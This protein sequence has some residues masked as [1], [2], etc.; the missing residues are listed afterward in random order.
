MS[1]VETTLGVTCACVPPIAGF[2]RKTWNQFRF[3]NRSYFWALKVWKDAVAIL[4]SGGTITSGGGTR[5]AFPDI[6]G[7][8]HVSVHQV[9]DVEVAPASSHSRSTEKQS[10]IEVS[11]NPAK[12]DEAPSG[13]CPEST[14]QRPYGDM[15]STQQARAKEEPGVS[16]VE[17]RKE[18]LPEGH[19]EVVLPSVS[20][21]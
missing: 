17:Q 11:V 2:V 8:V 4:K 20:R 16:G 1:T 18:E 12:Q 21:L 5:P 14:E 15:T 13:H 6:C 3:A 9:E 7:N 19:E 10:R